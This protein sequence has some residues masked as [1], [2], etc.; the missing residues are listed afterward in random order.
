MDE[1]GRGGS[2]EEEESNDLPDK[3]YGMGMVRASTGSNEVVTAKAIKRRQKIGR[4]YDNE[5]NTFRC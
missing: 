5:D 3:V 1:S 2:G 4:K